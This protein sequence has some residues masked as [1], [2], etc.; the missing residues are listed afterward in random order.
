MCLR[1]LD[2]ASQE[3]VLRALFDS[4]VGAGFSAM[5]T[6]IAATDFMS[7]GPYYTYDDVSG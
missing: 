4:R 2:L 3:A 5:K 6:V 1:S 7:A